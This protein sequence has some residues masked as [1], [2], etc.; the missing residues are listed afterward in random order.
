MRQHGRLETVIFDMDGVVIDSEPLWSKAERE[1]LACRN[2]SYAPQLKS[3]LM[4]RNSREAVTLLIEHYNLNERLDR[5]IHEREELV[6][7]L[8]QRYL[9]PIPSVLE[10]IRSIRKEGIKTA[11]T[12]SSSQYL[13][14]LALDKLGIAHQFD[15]V[16]SDDQVA[17]GKPAPDGYLSAA[18]QLE[19]APENCLV[20]EDAPNGVAAAKAAGMRC[21][22]VST[23]VN[24]AELGTADLVVRGFEEVDVSMLRELVRKA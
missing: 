11:L 3:L 19:A 14:R 23:S 5:V 17:R 9:Q 13:V 16:V 21:L 8:Y 18:K 22:A 15:H 1:L 2:L 12:S 20:I 24:A 10:L 7:G 6:A 4:G